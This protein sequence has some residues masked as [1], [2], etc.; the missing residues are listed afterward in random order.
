MIESE[1][2]PLEYPEKAEDWKQVSRLYQIVFFLCHNIICYLYMLS[3]L[4]KYTHFFI[5]LYTLFLQVGGKLYSKK[6]DNDDEEENLP[7][8]PPPPPPTR[9]VSFSID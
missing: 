6:N 3:Y 8:L 4:E 7:P 2:Y 9:V 1:A 5:F